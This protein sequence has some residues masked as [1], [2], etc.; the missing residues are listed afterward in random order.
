VFLGCFL[1]SLRI[2]DGRLDLGS[3]SHNTS[4]AYKLLKVRFVE[5]RHAFYGEIPDGPLEA[6][7]FLVDHLPTQ[8]GEENDPRH[9]LEVG[10]VIRG[11]SI[12]VHPLWRSPVFFTQCITSSR[13]CHLSSVFLETVSQ[14]LGESFLEAPPQR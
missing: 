9:I 10:V 12:S 3:I 7:P 13:F 4:V 11:P 1:K 5:G 14:S 2:L 8:S 6:G